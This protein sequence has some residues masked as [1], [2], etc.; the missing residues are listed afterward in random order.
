MSETIMIF[1]DEKG[2]KKH[3]LQK[4]FNAENHLCK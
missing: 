4:P 2:K 1:D 3:F